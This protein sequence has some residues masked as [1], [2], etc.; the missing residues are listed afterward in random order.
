MA[1]AA[2]NVDA[3]AQAFVRH[4]YSVYDQ[5][6]SKLGGLYVSLLFLNAS[7]RLTPSHSKRHPS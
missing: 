2:P 7:L 4:Y 6:R 3:V 5:D 1:Q